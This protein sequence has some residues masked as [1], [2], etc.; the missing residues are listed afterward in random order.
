MREREIVIRLRLPASPR[1]RWPLGAGA[2]V[3]LVGAVVYAAVPNVF[4]PGD[5]LSY[6]KMNDNFNA[7]VDLTTDQSIAGNKTVTGKLIISRNGKT[8]SLG[9]VY[10]GNVPTTPPTFPNGLLPTGGYAGMKTLCQSASGCSA[11]A[12]MCTSDEIARSFSM[13]LNPVDGWYSTATWASDTGVST[14]AVSDCAAWTSASG[15]IAGAALV[16]GKPI[17]HSCA[18]ANIPIVCCD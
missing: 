10:C 6:Q 1:W 16:G 12:H 2:A 3:V 15:T 14:G 7:L 5:S 11:S 9:A 13:G 18:A 8:Y 17:D 4:K